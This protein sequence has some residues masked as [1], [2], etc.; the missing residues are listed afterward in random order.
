MNL[1]LFGWF[2]STDL[3]NT[4]TNINIK[5]LVYN[6]K[7]QEMQDDL[8]PFGFINDGQNHGEDFT[9]RDDEGDL[10]TKF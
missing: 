9:G 4:L 6:Q 1:V 8:L 5:D 7:L 10:W 2:A 3:F